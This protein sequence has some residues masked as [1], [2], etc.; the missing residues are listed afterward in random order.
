MLLFRMGPR[1]LF[2]RTEDIE[3]T[4]KF[5]EKSLNGEVI[6]FQQGMGR[7]SENSTLCFITGINYEK[8]YIEDARKIVLINDVASVIL[9]TIINSRGYNLLQKIDMGP[10]S[11]IMRIAGDESKL[12]DRVKDLFDGKEVDWIEGIGMGEKDDTILA[13]TKKSINGP[14]VSSDILDTKILVPRPSIEV[15]GKLR[16]EGLRLMTQSLKDSQWYEL[17]INIYD[18]MGEYQKHYDRLMFILSKLEMGMV[19][20]ESWT[21]DYAVLLYSV[22]TYQ[23]RLFTFFTPQEVKRI[24]AAL[25]YTIDGKRLVDFDLYHKNKK[26]SWLDVSP[27]NRKVKKADEVKAYRQS[28]YEKLTPEDINTLESME[29]AIVSSHTKAP[30]HSGSRRRKVTD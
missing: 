1:Y 25:E 28:M 16:L 9:S 12:I 13:F 6:G 7:A 8:T 24:L 15:R 27:A 5:L 11:M 10:T 17:R 20:G 18:S 26:I 14:L 30:T 29:E 2:I 4:T 19:L 23:V 22:M 21:K 3:G